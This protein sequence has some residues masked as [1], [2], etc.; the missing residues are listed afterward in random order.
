MDA[1]DAPTWALYESASDQIQIVAIMIL[2]IQKHAFT[3]MH[4]PCRFMKKHPL[5]TK[6]ILNK[7]RIRNFL[8]RNL[9][10]FLGQS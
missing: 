6:P 3:N 4:S 9:Q 7:D 1:L 8:E 5:T 10:T 2:V